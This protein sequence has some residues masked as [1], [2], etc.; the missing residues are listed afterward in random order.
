M[1]M[2]NLLHHAEFPTASDITPFDGQC[3]TIITSLF[4]I[5][6]HDKTSLELNMAKATGKAASRL[7]PRELRGV[8]WRSRVAVLAALAQTCRQCWSNGR[9]EWRG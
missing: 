1:A 9:P 4:N 2:L 8:P 6:E 5:M 3:T 7:M